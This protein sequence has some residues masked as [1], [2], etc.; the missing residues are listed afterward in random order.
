MATGSLL[1]KYKD[2][3]VNLL[4][5]GKLWEP[6]EQPVF[7]ALLD[8][9][10]DEFCR[11]EQRAIDLL[12]EADPRQTTQAELLPDWQRL[13]GLPDEC[14]PEVQTIDEKQ[15]QITQKYTNVG[16]LSKSF[17]EELTLNLGFVVIVENRVNFVAGR[18]RAGDKLTNYFN[19]IFEAGDTAGTPLRE[20]GWR[21]YFEVNMPIEAATVFVAGS[22]AGDPL[23]T[24]ENEVIECTMQKLK[25]A[26]A[27]IFPTFR[28]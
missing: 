14:T 9:F 20:I 6:K 4:P 24:F 25:P 18:A 8:A 27:A 1:A 16:G 11:V 2:L 21:F 19:R 15:Q 10:A 26:H 12:F 3:L 7:K 5:K 28:T 13:L 17:Y 23:R 22:L